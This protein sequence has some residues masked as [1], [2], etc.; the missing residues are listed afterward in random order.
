MTRFHRKATTNSTAFSRCMRTLFYMSCIV[1]AGCATPQPPPTAPK[2]TPTLAHQSL[3]SGQLMAVAYSG[4]REGQH[5]DIGGGAVNPSREQILDDLERL[6]RHGF[7]LIRVYDSG[8]NAETI[9]NLIKEHDLPIKVLLG[10]WLN[11]EVSNHDGCPWL[12]DPIPTAVLE[13]N[14]TKNKQEVAK[15]VALANQ[16]HD[17]VI[18]VNVGNEALVDWNDHMVSV[19]SVITYVREVKASIQQPVTVADNYVW[20]IKHGK[21]LA[22]VVDF[23]GVHSYPVWES[24][25]IEEA[26]NYTEA[27]ISAVRAAHP[28]KRL[29]ILEAGWATTA[30][31]FGGRAGEAQQA[32]YFSELRGW[33]H[34]NQTTVFFFEAFD[35]P[36]KGDPNNPLGAEKHWGL[37]KVD[38]SPKAVVIEHLPEIETKPRHTH[39]AP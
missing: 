8:V 7:Q 14:R 1:V 20:W 17:Q 10:I 32:R 3:L 38:R 27:N 34:S 5:P 21:G 31:E 9:L 25:S 26:I 19:E 11:A 29:A 37:F 24:K 28:D 16:F 30:E 6:S 18:A 12:S 33:A 22:E 39:S 2:L 15:G 36:W 13:A 4:Y 23:I 35:E